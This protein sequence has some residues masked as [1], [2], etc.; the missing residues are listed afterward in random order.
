MHHHNAEL[1][2]VRFEPNPTQWWLQ[3]DTRCIHR[4]RSV[5]PGTDQL[6]TA[7]H[8]PVEFSRRD[9]FVA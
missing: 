6:V 5:P 3:P 2:F 4:F 7:R 9:T 8:N 1:E